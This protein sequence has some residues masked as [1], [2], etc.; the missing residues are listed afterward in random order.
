V[1]NAPTPTPL[2]AT[3]L[4]AHWIFGFAAGGVRDVIVQ[5]KIVVADRNALTIDGDALAA[6]ARPVSRRLWSRLESLPEHP[7]M[8][9]FTAAAGARR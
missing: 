1:L 6:A 5:G 8:P 7:F 4:A 2:D 3:N 9:S